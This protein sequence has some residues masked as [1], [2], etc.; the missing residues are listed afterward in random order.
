METGDARS[1]II[2]S[3][4]FLAS[5]EYIKQHQ[6]EKP[7]N[8]LLTP[9]LYVHCNTLSPM[10]KTRSPLNDDDANDDH[11][12]SSPED[13]IPSGIALKLW[14]QSKPEKGSPV[15]SKGTGG[16]GGWDAGSPPKLGSAKRGMYAESK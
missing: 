11:S 5:T 10:L 8:L 13:S 1:I 14:R 2:V 16:G 9:Y 12:A 6:K 4:R 15:R 7:V 3:A